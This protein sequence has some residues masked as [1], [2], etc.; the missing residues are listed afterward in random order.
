[1]FAKK[2]KENVSHTLTGQQAGPQTVQLGA[3][4]TAHSKPKKKNRDLNRKNIADGRALMEVKP[5]DLVP[6]D[7]VVD[8]RDNPYD[9]FESV[10]LRTTSYI[11]SNSPS[12]CC[13]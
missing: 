5:A 12:V 10:P 13:L 1:M 2:D 7:Y 9:V 3:M 6:P 8:Y 4:K 11:E